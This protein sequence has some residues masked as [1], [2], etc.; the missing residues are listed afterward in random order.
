MTGE[1]A[2]G[3]AVDI[4]IARN[5]VPLPQQRHL[6]STRQFQTCKPASE[7]LPSQG[8]LTYQVS[9]RLSCRAT[10]PHMKGTYHRHSCLYRSEPT[11]AISSGCCCVG[12]KAAQGWHNI[13]FPDP[14]WNKFFMGLHTMQTDLC[15]M[16]TC[17]CQASFCLVGNL[18]MN[19]A[20]DTILSNAFDTAEHHFDV[21]EGDERQRR[22]SS[23]ESPNGGDVQRSISASL[24][25]R[26]LTGESLA[27]WD[28]KPCLRLQSTT[29]EGDKRLNRI[30]TNESPHGRTSE[31][32]PHDAYMVTSMQRT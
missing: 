7:G 17:E 14:I 26:H 25:N 31:E 9:V 8:H 22:T 24:F 28:A 6:T 5:H 23:R 18:Q 3:I 2:S 15:L 20:A 27:A 29:F 10:Y 21:M 30:S 4:V 11:L 32:G 12:I 19:T 1:L 16:R 13:A